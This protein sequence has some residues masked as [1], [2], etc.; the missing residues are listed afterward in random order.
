MRASVQPKAL[1]TSEHTASTSLASTLLGACS[2]VIAHSSCRIEK[3]MKIILLISIMCF[4]SQT[5]FAMSN[6]DFLRLSSDSSTT[7]SKEAATVYVHGVSMGFM[8]AEILGTEKSI[9]FP[10]KLAIEDINFTSLVKSEMEADKT[11]DGEYPVAV[12]LF[13]AYKRR[14][15]CK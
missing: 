11:V 12:T 5:S 6:D 4:F 9:C 15:P 1:S 8:I 14:F 13:R 10:R 3:K 7:R 2:I